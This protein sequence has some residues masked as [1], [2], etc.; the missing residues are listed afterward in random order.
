[1]R[2]NF[3]PTVS[4]SSRAITRS[5]RARIDIEQ[6]ISETNALQRHH[7]LQQL[8]SALRYFIETEHAVYLEGLGMLI[9]VK[10]RI[11]RAGLPGFAG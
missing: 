6:F 9:P 11:T 5:A 1:M 8:D 7:L 2:S 10:K 3:D 4:D